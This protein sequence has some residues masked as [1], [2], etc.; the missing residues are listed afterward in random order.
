M[1][2]GKTQ[3]NSE[4]T[5]IGWFDDK[6][7]KLDTNKYKLCP[8]CKGSGESDDEFPVRC[9]KCSGDG[10]ISKNIQ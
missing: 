1:E 10:F 8:N 4:I 5:F 3:K 9:F 6:P 2:D 7:K